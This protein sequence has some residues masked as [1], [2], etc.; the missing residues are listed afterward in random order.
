M[1]G[2]SEMAEL[3]TAEVAEILWAAAGAQKRW[4][5]VKADV[6]LVGYAT[7]TLIDLGFPFE[8]ILAAEFRE[9]FASQVMQGSRYAYESGRRSA[10]HE[11]KVS[12]TLTGVWGLDDVTVQ[13]FLF[14]TVTGRS[15]Q[16]R[17]QLGVTTREPA[18]SAYTQSCPSTST[19]GASRACGL[20]SA[21][22]AMS[23]G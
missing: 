15:E 11:F 8:R 16:T 22:R 6:Q 1:R 3:V 13:L 20:R 14:D 4:D 5:E 19:S 17:L 21:I 7:S 9:F 18:A 2:V 23:D 10:R 12:P